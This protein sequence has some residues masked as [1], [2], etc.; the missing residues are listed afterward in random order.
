MDDYTLVVGVDKK[1]LEQLRYTWPTWRRHKP[2]LLKVP[3]V[4]FYDWN[5]LMEWE[6]REVVDHPRLTLVAWQVCVKNYRRNG[7]QTKWNN[8]Q[9]CKMLA[10]FVHVPPVTVITRYW[11]KLDTDTVATGVDDWIDPGWFDDNPAIIS[12]PWGFTKPPDQMLKLDGWV[13]RCAKDLPMLSRCAPLDLR[14][15]EGS[16]RVRHHRIIS[17]CAFFH[18]RFTARAAGWAAKTMGAGMLPVPSQDGF[19]FYVAKRLG[20]GI[21]RTSM[22][23][24]GWHHWSTMI[25]IR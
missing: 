10:G 15:N 1:H 4:V 22:K 12:Q 23:K 5:Q 17:W 8:P 21:V 24:R 20:L 6:V 16:S 13:E 9:R 25:N 19:L 14:P 7:E 11:L 18:T 3:M 2:S